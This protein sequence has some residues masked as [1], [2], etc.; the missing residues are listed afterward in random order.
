MKTDIRDAKSIARQ[1]LEYFGL[2][3][4]ENRKLY[5]NLVEYFMDQ[6]PGIDQRP[7][8]TFLQGESDKIRAG[9]GSSSSG[10]TAAVRTRETKSLYET[11]AANKFT[12]PLKA[13]EFVQECMRL[14]IT[15]EDR[16]LYYD[17]WVDGTTPATPT[18]PPGNTPQVEKKPKDWRRGHK[19]EDILISSAAAFVLTLLA[20]NVT[21][22]MGLNRWW[23]LAEVL[24]LP[25]II[26]QFVR[27]DLEKRHPEEVIVTEVN[28]S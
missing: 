23:W 20:L 10:G 27:L 6:K 4:Q 11:A 28:K 22:R 17:D 8:R 5:D 12:N 2:N 26:F 19:L 21:A 7:M 16:A 18:N 14:G 13:E 9:G 1:E 3:I 24:A 15:A 25:F